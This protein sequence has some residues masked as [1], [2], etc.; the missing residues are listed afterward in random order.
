MRE[1]HRRTT[2][3]VETLRR[4]GV[5]ERDLQTAYVSVSTQYANRT[6]RPTAITGY[7][8]TNS[9]RARIRNLDNMGQVIDQAVAAGG[10]VVNGISLSLQAPDVQRDSAR[11]DAISKA[12]AR[13]TLYA[14]AL[15]MTVQRIVS[16]SEPGAGGAEQLELTGT[17]TTDNL[18]NELP[19]AISAPILPGE[20]ETRTTVNVTF[21][22]R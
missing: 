4:E 5:A 3:L 14:Q 17:M 12:R 9:V 1:N 2:A 11:R 18:L 6:G 19:Q 10:N 13:A 7:E 16:V 8:A 20:I 21:E 22:L 15:G